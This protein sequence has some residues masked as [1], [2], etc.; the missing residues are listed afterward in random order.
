M[1]GSKITSHPGSE[2]KLACPES[3]YKS[4]LNVMFC[5]GVRR[6]IGGKTLMDGCR[7]GEKVRKNSLNLEDCLWRGEERRGGKRKTFD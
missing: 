1:Y 2:R 4:E 7:V 6:K 5:L 3:E